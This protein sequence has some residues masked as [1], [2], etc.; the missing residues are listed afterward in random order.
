LTSFGTPSILFSTPSQT[1]VAVYTKLQEVA[2]KIT[3]LSVA[4]AIKQIAVILGEGLLSSVRVVVDALLDVLSSVAN[5]VIDPLDTNI[6]I[7]I[8]SDILEAIGVPSISFFDLFAWIGA[9]SFTLVYKIANGDVPF[10]DNSDVNA[11][12]SASSWDELAGLFGKSAD[13]T[14]ATKDRTVTLPHEVEKVVHIAGHGV[15]GFTTLMGCFLVRFEA[16][17]P[18]GDNPFS[19]PGAILSGLGLALIGV[20]EFLGVNNGRATSAIIDSILIIPEMLVTDWHLYEL[21]Q[22]PAGTERSAAIVGEVVHLTSDGARISYAIAVNDPYPVTKQ[23]AI[24]V[25]LACRVVTAGLQTAE[26]FLVE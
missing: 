19:L 20:A 17:F 22:K 5:T 7:P 2:I 12:K 6:Y 21:S 16:E 23:G 8:I 25:T 18:T 9:V 13:G 24:V 15:D 26:A 10:P 14:S 1:R 3:S 11:L 4:D